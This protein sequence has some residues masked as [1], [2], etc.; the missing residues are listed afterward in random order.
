VLKADRQ[1]NGHVVG[2]PCSTDVTKLCGWQTPAYQCRYW[3]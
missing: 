1:Y 3:C 2:K